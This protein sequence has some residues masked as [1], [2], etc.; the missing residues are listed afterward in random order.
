MP[1]ITQN[2]VKGMIKDLYDYGLEAYD[3]LEEVWPQIYE[4][5]KVDGGYWQDTTVVNNGTWR[6]T[7]ESEGYE[8]NNPTEGYTVYGRVFTYTTAAAFS[9]DTVDDHQKIK[10]L[11][12]AIAGDWGVG[13]KE[14]REEFYARPFNEGG[15][16]AGD[17]IFNGT[18]ESK[19]ITD[20][21]GDL[22]YDGIEF[23]NLIGN[24]RASK[25]GGTYYNAFSYVFDGD[26]LK[27]VLTYAQGTNNRRENDTRF[28]LKFNTL[29]VPIDL[30]MAS[31]E[32]L[33]STLVPY[34]TTN[35]SNVLQ[36]VLNPIEWS[37]LTDTDA[38]FVG[39]AKKGIVALKRQEP[40]FDFWQDKKT[41]CWWA[42]GKMRIGFMMK[43]WRFW[44][45]SQISAA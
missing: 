10:D 44:S 18:P 43:N 31:R 22:C 41:R 2:F 12:K 28:N 25:G 34:K 30:G 33:N 32:V 36:G 11:V 4:E 21:S 39:T 26:N 45:G 29:L 5:K 9:E 15:K 27:T 1:A 24:K 14:T 37:Y 6:K 7:T 23:F 38:W 42:T 3:S 8:E 17:W 13:A 40:V 16:T 19:A 35:T 20:T